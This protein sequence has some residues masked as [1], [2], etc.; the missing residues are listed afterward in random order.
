M[1]KTKSPRRTSKGGSW[2]K[3]K[4][5]TSEESAPKPL[6][7]IPSNLEGKKAYLQKWFDENRIPGKIQSWF[8]VPSKTENAD[9]RIV[10]RHLSKGHRVLSIEGPFKGARPPKLVLDVDQ[11]IRKPH[12]SKFRGSILQIWFRSTGDGR[13]GIAVQN[14]LHSAEAT[15][16]FKSFLEYLEHEHASDVLCCHQMQVR[17][18]QL[19]EP[20]APQTGVSVELKKGFGSPFLPIG[21]SG[22]KFSILDW[23]PVAKEPWLRLPARIREAIHPAKDDKFLECFAGPAFVSTSLAKNFSECYA[24]DQRDIA[25]QT[26]EVRYLHSSIDRDFFPKFFRGKSKQGK[27][28]VYLDPPGGKSLPGNTVSA[29]AAAAPERILLNTSNL[30]QA[31]LE[32]KRFRR[33]GYMLRKLIPLDLEPDTPSFQILLLFVPDR[34]GLLGHR[35]ERSAKVIRKRENQASSPDTFPETIRF[36]Q[37]R[38]SSAPH[39]RQKD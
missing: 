9:W 14:I 23:T 25:R 11:Q 33:E 5:L 17:P 3:Q 30:S 12:L 38:R 22:Q 15:R 4:D 6:D 26:P 20:S 36:T 10:S 39:S 7:P 27:W 16:E 21:G 8:T 37:K 2:N 19:L 24:V 29:L 34:A 1:I 28:T 13:F 32:I 31:A 18:V 35:P